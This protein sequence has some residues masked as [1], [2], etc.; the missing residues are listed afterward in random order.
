MARQRSSLLQLQ[1]GDVNTVAVTQEE[2]AQMLHTYFT[3]VVALFSLHVRDLNLIIT[4]HCTHDQHP[5]LL[6]R[7]GRTPMLPIHRSYTRAPAPEQ[8]RKPDAA[9]AAAVLRWS[10]ASPASNA[11]PPLCSVRI[12]LD[13]LQQT[14]RARPASRGT[15]APVHVLAV[16]LRHA[17]T[18]Q[19]G[20]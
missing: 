17:I 20:S 1:E 16:K 11:P 15:R 19:R 12:F 18:E 10:L 14:A 13:S 8:R 6:A 5:A 9:G 4:V 3:A 2:K 7:N